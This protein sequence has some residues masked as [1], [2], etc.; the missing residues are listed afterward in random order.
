[1]SVASKGSPPNNRGPTY[2]PNHVS[3]LEGWEFSSAAFQ[4]LELG[5]PQAETVGF[6]P[7]PCFNFFLVGWG[8]LLKS[9][10]KKEST[11]FPVATGRGPPNPENNF[12]RFKLSLKLGRTQGQDI[13][14]RTL[15]GK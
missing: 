2:T 3:S 9:A 15:P 4:L 1:M 13:G 11:F 10:T 7:K 6:C 8:F 14:G 5:K 12:R